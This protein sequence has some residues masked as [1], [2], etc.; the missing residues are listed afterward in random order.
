MILELW[1]ILVNDELERSTE[2]YG[3]GIC[4]RGLTKIEEKPLSRL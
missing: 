3:S 4:Q 2:G 1:G